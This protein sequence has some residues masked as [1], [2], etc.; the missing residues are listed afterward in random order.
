[1]PKIP[2]RLVKWDDVVYWSRELAKKIV[3]SEYQ[4][5]VV[6]AIARGGVAPARLLCDYLG[7]LDLLTI[8][9]EHWVD[10]AG[11]LLE[12]AVVKYPF[13]ADLSDSK[14]LLVDDICDTGRSIVVSKDYLLKHNKPKELRV[15]T[16][17]YIKPVAQI[18][19]DY[20]VEEVVDWVWYLYPWNYFEDT[21]NL[22]KK[23]LQ[24]N[25]VEPLS[26]SSLEEKF[27]ESYGIRPP[28][29]LSEAVAEGARRGVFKVL[30]GGFVKLH[31]RF[32]MA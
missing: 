27:F 2:V 15:A 21:I 14:V 18:T 8:K 32:F 20:Y 12:D 28:V 3:E 19:P 11:R 26:L 22:V 30:E 23:I 7:V 24:E 6:V 9:V 4:P 5:D 1:L 31:E 29:S 13:T 10:T 25:P 17:Q 16:M